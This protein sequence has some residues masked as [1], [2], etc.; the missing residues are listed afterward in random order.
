MS[1]MPLVA[2]SSGVCQDSKTSNVCL[3][4]TM[5]RTTILHVDDDPNDVLLLEQACARAGLSLHVHAVGDGDEALAYLRGTNGF[6]EREQHPLP[7]LGLL[8][9][10]MPRLNDFDC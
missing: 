4:L 9:L 1:V 5:N 7:S 6:A 2:K 3:E 8:D 10:K